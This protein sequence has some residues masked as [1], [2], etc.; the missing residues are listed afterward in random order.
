[1]S[2]SQS[3]YADVPIRI[4]SW[5]IIIVIVSIGLL[6]HTLTCL[7]FTLL[8]FIGFKEFLALE[9]QK[10]RAMLYS[11]V[12][13]SLF[14]F[15]TSWENNY[16]L[17]I[18]IVPLYALLLGLLWK[19]IWIFLIGIFI[20]VWTLGHLAFIPKLLNNQLSGI[21]LLLFLIILTELNDVFQ[22]LFGKSLG[23]RKISPF[24]SPNKT[25]EGLIGAVFSTTIISIPMGLFLIPDKNIFLYLGLGFLISIVGFC[26]DLFI[27]ALKRKANVKDTS[28]LIPGHGGLL[29]RMDSL[30][31]ISPIFYGLC[32][33]IF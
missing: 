20:N 25:K 1:M 29:D 3:K 17:F 7:L 24:I 10:N 14:Q 26:G 2:N 18:F 33:L 16:V 4:R 21:K 13:L 23:K 11:F 28:N 8:S 5:L 31:F 27:S 32:H 6:H 15:Y 22:Y 19:R 9:K 30:I 12:P